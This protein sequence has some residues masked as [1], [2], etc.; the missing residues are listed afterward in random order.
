[1]GGGSSG[2]SKED[3]DKLKDVFKEKVDEGND[4]AG[5]AS[6]ATDEISESQDLEGAL[7]SFPVKCQD[8]TIIDADVSSGTLF[9]EKDSVKATISFE[10]YEV[11]FFERYEYNFCKAAHEIL[12][13]FGK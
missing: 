6:G 7:P 10:Q 5:D 13:K 4:V 1:M 8:G 3:I 12:T 2:Y 11:E 9:L